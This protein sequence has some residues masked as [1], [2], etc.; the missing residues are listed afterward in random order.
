MPAR[1]YQTLGNIASDVSG[2][3]KCADVR[4][5][6]NLARFNQGMWWGHRIYVFRA[7]EMRVFFCFDIF[8]LGRSVSD[9]FCKMAHEFE[10]RT[11]LIIGEGC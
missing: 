5:L 11:D 10:S 4:R 2:G 9:R 8:F 6:K 3:V 7:L 1:I